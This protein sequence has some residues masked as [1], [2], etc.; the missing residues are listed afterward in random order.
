MA[1]QIILGPF[2][3]SS[4]VQLLVWAREIGSPAVV[5]VVLLADVVGFTFLSVCFCGNTYRCVRKLFHINPFREVTDVS[6]I[7][8][9]W[10]VI[11]E[12]GKIQRDRKTFPL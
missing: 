8:L 4:S 9:N 12:V 2:P 6:V 10:K 7:L 1:M 5:T 3:S 11:M